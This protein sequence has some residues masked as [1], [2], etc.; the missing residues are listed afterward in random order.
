MATMT[1]KDGHYF[2]GEL[3]KVE[4]KLKNLCSDYDAVRLKK[5][6]VS[7]TTLG[8]AR[9][10]VGQAQLLLTKRLPQ[11]DGLCELNIHPDPASDKPAKNEDLDGF[12]DLVTLAVDDVLDMFKVLQQQE[13]NNWDEPVESPKAQPAQPKFRRSNSVS[14]FPRSAPAHR[15]RKPGCGQPASHELTTCQTCAT[16]S[17]Q[18]TELNGELLAARSLLSVR[19]RDLAQTR[20]E[21]ADTREL[22]RQ[23]DV[24]K[25][26][27]RQSQRSAMCAIS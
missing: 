20:E 1:V 12:W 13:A 14:G 9:T 16:L 4:D 25:Q 11:F 5:Q 26:T 22:L 24:A 17:S 2:R 23:L 6:H 3:R 27:E 19:D 15:K 21:L 8:R 18:V 10:A 7:E